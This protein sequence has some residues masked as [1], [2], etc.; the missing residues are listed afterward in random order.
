VRPE[1][2]INYFFDFPDIEQPL[3]R[4]CASQ[5]GE[6]LKSVQAQLRSRVNSLI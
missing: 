4:V 5:S 2:M 6:V 3:K 1:N